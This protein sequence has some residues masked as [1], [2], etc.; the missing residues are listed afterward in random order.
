MA[1]QMSID[2]KINELIYGEPINS[3]V[4]ER[5][6]KTL[7]SIN[8]SLT[9]NNNY[10]DL[11]NLLK[12]SDVNNAN[13]NKKE[14]TK[15]HLQNTSKFNKVL[16]NRNGKSYLNV[17]ELLEDADTYGVLNELFYSSKER[18]SKYV[19]YD[20]IDNLIPEMHRILET[21]TSNIISPDD[22]TS[23]T[24]KY[25]VVETGL[26]E[27]RIK[28]LNS[29]LREIEK[30]YKL[31]KKVK[32]I[33]RSGEKY[34]DYYI[35]TI[36]LNEEINSVLNEDATEYTR[37]TLNEDEIKHLKS[38]IINEEDKTT[39]CSNIDLQHDFQNFIDDKFNF[40]KNYTLLLEEEK[41][42]K[43]D[44]EKVESASS[45]KIN[46]TGTLLKKIDPTKMVKLFVGETVVG[47]YYLKYSKDENFGKDQS[48]NRVNNFLAYGQR[49]LTT[50]HKNSMGTEEGRSAFLLDLITKKLNIKLDKKFLSNNPEFRNII[51]EIL[52][53]VKNMNKKVNVI[54]IPADKLIHFKNTDTM[55]G[56]SLFKPILFT[57]KLYLA[58]LMSTLMQKLIRAPEKRVFY[59]STGLD[60]DTEGA[61]I[62]FMRDIK[63]KDI[64]LNDLGEVDTA[65][66]KATAFQDLYVPVVDGEKPIDIETMPGSD[67]SLENDFLEY[68][69]KTM[70]TGTGVP[71]NF[72]GSSDEVE[73]A[74]SI[75]MQNGNLVKTIS[76]KQIIYGECFVELFY[77]LYKNEFPEDTEIREE[78]IFAMFP[79]PNT[80]K[81]N[82][83]SEAIGNIQTLSDFINQTFNGDEEN[84]L[85]KE[86][87]LKLRKKFFSQ[88]KWDEI[89]DIYNDC[90]E[91]IIKKNKQKELRDELEKLHSNSDSS[92]DNTDDSSGDDDMNL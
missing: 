59:I 30:K 55:Y 21:I 13:K 49:N 26:T 42:L 32:G 16:E 6:K 84:E 57:A 33:I 10:L 34:G 41:K 19:S 72:I 81:N 80:L 25:G 60:E 31:Q 76:E 67:V 43:E 44:I 4:E 46:F 24:I 2:D 88:I 74:R 71:A 35:A 23:S 66:N 68:L 17:N 61:V 78:N 58:A 5:I 86:F 37:I 87:K 85:S 36:N 47:Y 89:E 50:A 20:Q 83:Y 90:K 54:F 40:T 29:R 28:T 56:E 7:D 15:N 73:F 82:N 12:I 75:T 79:P 62:S 39:D 92:E 48:V 70:I 3:K 52:K 1:K 69:K 14:K 11:N 64:T 91:E 18:F 65:M 77:K 9:N 53:D 45:S 8:I 63:A 51:A 38:I 27:E 22:F